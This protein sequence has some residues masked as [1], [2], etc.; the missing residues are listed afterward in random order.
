MDNKNNTKIIC[1]LDGGDVCGFVVVSIGV[2][3]GSGSGSGGGS[4]G[5]GGSG[6][7]HLIDHLTEIP[8]FHYTTDL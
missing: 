1:Y 5:S 6:R 8:H 4:G 3:V 7:I 2:V